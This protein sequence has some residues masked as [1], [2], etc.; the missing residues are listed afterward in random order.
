[1]EEKDKAYKRIKKGY[2]QLRARTPESDLLDM[3]IFEKEIPR[4]TDRFNDRYKAGIKDNVNDPFED[5]YRRADEIHLT[6]ILR[7]SAG[8]EVYK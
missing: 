2:E 8:L 3:I 6:D 7:A 5:R 1:M 4:Y